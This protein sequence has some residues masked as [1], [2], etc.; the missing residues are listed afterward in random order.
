MPENSGIAGDAKEAMDL[1]AAE[2]TADLMRAA[3]QQ[4]RQDQR[5]TI[6]GDDII[7]AMRSLGFKNYVGPLGRAAA[8]QPA[9]SPR[10]P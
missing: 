4:C 8:P 2:F 5:S 10:A 1:C 9:A 6:T 3:W 7:L